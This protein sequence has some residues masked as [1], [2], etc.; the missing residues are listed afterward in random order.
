M[1]RAILFLAF[2]GFENSHFC[3]FLL[4]CTLSIKMGV[5][6]GSSPGASTFLYCLASTQTLQKLPSSI[7]AGLRVSCAICILYSFLTL[8]VAPSAVQ[9]CFKSFLLFYP[10]CFFMASGSGPSAVNFAPKPYISLQNKINNLCLFGY[11][12]VLASADL[13]AAV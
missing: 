11:C 10:C 12:G 6:Q 3:R 2:I 1:L 13:F 9:A 7:L 4:S 5:P 8:S